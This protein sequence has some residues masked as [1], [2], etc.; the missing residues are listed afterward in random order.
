MRRADN[1]TTLICQLSSNLGALTSWNP[2]GLSWHVQGL[3]YLYL[4]Y[5][6]IFIRLS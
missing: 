3:L 5:L 1:L 6:D 4:Y 2:Q